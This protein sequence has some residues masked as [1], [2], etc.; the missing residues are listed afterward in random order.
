MDTTTRL[1]S[2][3]VAPD[4]I[5]GAAVV[6]P[7][8]ESADRTVHARRRVL[9][10]AAFL[11][12]IGLA[13]QYVLSTAGLPRDEAGPWLAGLAED[14]TRQVASVVA[15]LLAMVGGV[16]GAVVFALAGRRR[17]PWLSGIAA[18][19]LVV[20]AV[21]GAGF[22]GMRLVAIE[23]AEIGGSSSTE[24]WEAVQAGAPFAVLGAMVV[25]AILGTLVG[26]VAAFRARADIAVW[27]APA[28]VVG[29]VLASGEFPVW[30]SVVGELVALVALVPVARAALRA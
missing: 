28:M 4:H 14:P 21:G 24:A 8:A 11:G 9:V 3:V 13:V 19:M 29:F 2:G 27:A 30:V 1:G 23:L 16:A 20:G 12:P 10:G 5:D 26:A 15:Y 18:A 7:A 17:A 25:F 6:T 22:A